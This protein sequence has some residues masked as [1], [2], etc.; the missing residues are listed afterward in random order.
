M[1]LPSQIRFRS[2]SF[3]VYR[4]R[5][6]WV[7]NCQQLISFAG[8]GHIRHLP[9]PQ[10]RL[11]RRLP[12]LPHQLALGRSMLIWSS[13]E[14]ET[15][16]LSTWLNPSLVVGGENWVQNR[17]ER[18]NVGFSFAVLRD[19]SVSVAVAAEMCCGYQ[20]TL[21]WSEFSMEASSTVCSKSVS[22]RKGLF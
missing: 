10:E 22:A 7:R 20:V 16:T 11:S 14:R 4:N 21:E 2:Q 12:E 18:Y 3:K 1:P 17:L 15:Q 13:W 6:H 19:V 8:P 9:W 5:F